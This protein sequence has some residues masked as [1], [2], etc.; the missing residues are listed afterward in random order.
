MKKI[1]NNYVGVP[2]D[3]VNANGDIVSAFFLFGIMIYDE[4]P[5]QTPIGESIVCSLNYSISYL[6]NAN[7]YNSMK[8][9][10][11]LDGETYESVLLSSATFKVISANKV[12]PKAQRPDLVG[13][14]SSGLSSEKTFTFFD[15]KMSLYN[16]LSS[17]FWTLC[18]VR[19]NG[20]SLETQDVNIPIYIRVYPDKTTSD[21]YDFDD[22]VDIWTCNIYNG[23]FNVINL[24]TKTR[25]L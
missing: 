23:D 19:K 14:I 13:S 22:I 1:R 3:L 11:S 7:S 5:M 25:S 18:A 12:Q 16:A 10:I 21:Y 2:Q 8:I 6:N 9:E 15:Y 4:E 20:E 24:S 17:K